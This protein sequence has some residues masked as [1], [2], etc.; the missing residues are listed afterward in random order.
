MMETTIEKARRFWME[1]STM[2][3]A[4][5]SAHGLPQA[6]PL[7]YAADDDTLIFVSGSKSRHSLNLAANGKAAA[8]IF[9]ETWSWLEIAG[10]QMEGGVSVIPVGAA[11]ERAW[12]VYRAKFPFVDEF[13]A[14]VSR[15]EFYR[16]APGWIRWID[17]SVTFGHKEEVSLG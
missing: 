6:A 11:R 13:Q 17:N 3:L 5:V 9:N 10:L 16:F 2:T 4:T 8:V 14:D 1:H 7:F 12:A 15:S